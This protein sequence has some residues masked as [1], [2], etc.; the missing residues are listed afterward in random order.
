MTTQNDAFNDDFAEL[1][2]QRTV[3]GRAV[4]KSGIEFTSR[5]SASSLP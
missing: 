4:L 1:G 3:R 5:P 2:G